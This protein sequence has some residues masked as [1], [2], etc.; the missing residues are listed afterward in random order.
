MSIKPLIVKKPDRVKGLRPWCTKCKRE[1]GNQKCGE[2]G[3]KITGCNSLESHTYKALINVPGAGRKVKTRVLNTRDLKEATI[4]KLQFEEELKSQEYQTT[5]VHIS[6]E[7]IKPVLLLEC[8]S[9]YLA[10]LNNVNV[11]P[12]MV[13]ERTGKHL[14]EV[15]NYFEKFCRAL[16]S[17]HIS[18]TIFRIDQLNDKVVAHFHT[19]ILEELKHEN[20][21]YNKMMALMR[22]FIDWLITQRQY[23]ISNSF[24]FVQRRIEHSDKTIVSEKEFDAFLGVINPENRYHILP[25]GK[26]KNRYKDW[27]S[28][29]FRLALETG[30]RR[31]EFMCLQFSDIV[32]GD[33]GQPLF[34]KVENY[35]VNRIKG[36]ESVSQ[37]VK[38]IP[39]TQ[40]LIIL[41]IELGI[42]KY[43][44][45]DRFLIGHE[46]KS[47]RNTLIDFVSKAFTFYW[48]QTGIDKK[49]QLK[50][51]RKTYLTAL[52]EHFGD[53]APMISDHSGIQVLKDHYVNNQRLV[54]ASQDFSI[55]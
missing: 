9:M 54:S 37:E 16:K 26:R 19:Y 45:T 7:S 24:K 36:G 12:H 10:Y 33:D 52:V 41:L 42:E 32:L 44:G 48:K 21:T 17:N 8:M 25:D 55:F 34:L 3:K 27:L 51:L 23:E 28:H 40:G 29:C 38:S 47:S 39:I 49:V 4:L 14:W 30:L 5:T 43:K 53:K 35:K 18:H 11:E 31:E 22:Q 1:I 15:E 46:E 13:K 50:H 20:K 6:Q 2:T